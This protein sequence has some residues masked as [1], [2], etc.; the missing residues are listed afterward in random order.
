MNKK[1]GVWVAE[2]QERVSIRVNLVEFRLHSVELQGL[3]TATKL[4]DAKRREGM[5]NGKDG[6]C[7][8]V[9][10]MSG[11]SQKRR[12]SGSCRQV[13]VREGTS[14]GKGM[15]SRPAS[16]SKTKLRKVP[17]SLVQTKTVLRLSPPPFF[18]C[19]IQR[20]SQSW[21]LVDH[22]IVQK[23]HVDDL[24]LL[25]YSSPPCI[26]VPASSAPPYSCLGLRSMS[27]MLFGVVRKHLLD[28]KR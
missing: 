18:S 19:G 11:H 27:W 22:S 7:L 9:G 26:L 25:A 6:R 2:H 1:W 8:H 21:Q 13:A 16:G 28:A 24:S 10:E 12:R 4:R 3:T 5:D 23:I 17:Y 15:P 14:N 20:A